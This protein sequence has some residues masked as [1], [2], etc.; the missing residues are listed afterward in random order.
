MNVFLLYTLLLHTLT[1]LFCV[2]F[3]SI[4]LV[5]SDCN[6][7]LASQI[8]TI[9]FIPNAT[10]HPHSFCFSLSIFSL[11]PLVKYCPRKIFDTHCSITISMISSYYLVTHFQE[12]FFSC[13]SILFVNISHSRLS[14]TSVSFHAFSFVLLHL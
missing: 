2:Y 14:F 10:G 9:F 1:L 3:H 4:I 8:K 5:E 7:A 13:F 12:L 6:L 11:F